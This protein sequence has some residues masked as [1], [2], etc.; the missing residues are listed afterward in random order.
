MGHS[1]CALQVPVGRLLPPRVWRSLGSESKCAG[2]LY[3]FAPKLKGVAKVKVAE[4]KTPNAKMAA[5]E[6]M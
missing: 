1:V 3:A 4:R 5:I 6:A 2:W